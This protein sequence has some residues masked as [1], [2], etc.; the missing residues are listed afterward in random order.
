[1]QQGSGGIGATILTGQEVLCLP[2]AG[3]YIG[4]ARQM[5]S[6]FSERY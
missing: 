1:M 6:T 4:P 3:F 5:L 2:Y